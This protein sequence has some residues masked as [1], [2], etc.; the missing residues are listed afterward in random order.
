[1]FKTHFLLIKPHYP[2][3][4]Q[5]ERDWPVSVTLSQIPFVASRYDI[6][7]Y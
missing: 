7:M 3:I 6:N 1:M 4:A 2:L 5:L